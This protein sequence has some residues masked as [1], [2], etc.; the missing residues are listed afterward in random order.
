MRIFFQNN[1]GFFGHKLP[2][3]LNDVGLISLNYKS[4]HSE[5]RQCYIAKN[6]S[7]NTLL[8]NFWAIQFV[9]L[10]LIHFSFLFRIN[11]F[12]DYRVTPFIIYALYIPLFLHHFKTFC[13]STDVSTHRIYSREYISGKEK[14]RFI[15]RYNIKSVL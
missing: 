13:L 11:N 4:Q 9:F 10:Q 6:I 3:K 5:N 15:L 12:V 2:R 8:I 7:V 14:H 1:E